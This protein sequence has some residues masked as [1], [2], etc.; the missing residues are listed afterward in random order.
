MWQWENNEIIL[1]FKLLQYH[2]EM[3]K[4]QIRIKIVVRQVLEK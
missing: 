4:I 3:V 1:L 2:C